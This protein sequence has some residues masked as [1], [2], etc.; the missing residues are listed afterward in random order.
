VIGVE[1]IHQWSVQIDHYLLRNDLY[2]YYGCPLDWATEVK[3]ELKP[4]VGS[5]KILIADAVFTKDGA[6]YFVE[7][8]RTQSMVENKKKIEYYAQVAH[9]VQSQYPS[10]RLVF[11]T[12]TPTRRETLSNLCKEKGLNFTVYTKEDLA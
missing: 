2:V 3:L 4:S 8:D 9:L 12:V 6:C 11:Y 5:T 10:Y 1:D 7:V